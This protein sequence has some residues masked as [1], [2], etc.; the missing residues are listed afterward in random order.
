MSSA[1]PS[2]GASG[3]LGAC[4]GLFVAFIALQACGSAA[5]A[6]HSNALWVLVDAGC[7]QGW[8]PVPS[9]YCDRARGDAVLKDI[10]GGTHYLL[11]PTARRI[12]VESAELLRDDEPDYFDD[13]WGARDRVIAASGRS[14]VRSDEI[15]LAINSRWGRSQDQ[16]REGA[17]RPSLELF[18]HTY[19]IA[20]VAALQKPT[21]FQRAAVAEDTPQQRETNTIGVVGDGGSGFYLLFGHAD[22]QGLDRGHAEEILVPRH[23]TH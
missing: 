20:H 22:L 12:G 19:R 4:I 21:P 16:L 6:G 23:C 13:A 17:M 5:P 11:I 1:F 7:N 10:C 18:G 2:P 15:G 3:R 9:L 14:D 8:A